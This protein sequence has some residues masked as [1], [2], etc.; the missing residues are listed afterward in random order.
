MGVA[1]ALI[2][3]VLDWAKEQAAT[4]VSLDVMRHNEHAQAL[5]RRHDFFAT[6]THDPAPENA[7][8]QCRLTH[9]L[10]RPEAS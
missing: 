4:C 2:E 7:A 8:A 3:A 1:D 10:T 5:Y 9:T 6:E